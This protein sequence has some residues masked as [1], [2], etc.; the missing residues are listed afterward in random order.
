MNL[1][2]RSY[3]FLHLAVFLFGFTG[4]LGD[5]I[6][7]PAIIL[8][9]WRAL[10]TWTIMSPYMWSSGKWKKITKKTFLIFLGIGVIVALHWICFYGSIKLA[11]SSVAMICLATISIMTAFFEAWLNKKRIQWTDVF[12]GILIIPG[13]LLIIQNISADFRVGFW[14]GILAAAF[15]ALFAALNKKYIATID[16]ISLTWIE[17][18]S[19]WLF[20]T[21]LL[22]IIYWQMPEYKFL[23]TS[24]DWLYLLVLSI[25][26]TIVAYVLAVKALQHLSAFSTM[27][28]FNLEPVYGIILSILILKE[29]KEFNL[30]FY[31]G[32]F[33]IFVSIFIHPYLNNKIKPEIT[34]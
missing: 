30:W 7:L 28:T 34:S 5:L 10:L 12:I 17:L 22:P 20:I 13:I 33:I 9:W 19:V 4:I 26:C 11:N 21:L 15:S 23:P 18:F 14:I 24:T 6:L 8:V 29:Y 25:A 16:P 32:V 31:V 1:I 3:L 27:L 2:Q